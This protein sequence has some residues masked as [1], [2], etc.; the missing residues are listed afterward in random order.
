M[1]KTEIGITAISYPMPCS[2]IGTKVA[3]KVNFL[4]VAWF[5]MV[6][7][8]PPYLMV[9]LGKA[10]Y[11]NEGIKENG[12]FSVNIPSVDMAEAVDYCGLVSGKKID[13]SGVFE[14]FYGKT[15]APMVKECPYNLECK[16]VQTVELPADEMF[17]GE[18]VAAY[19]DSGFLTG[20]V[21]DMS[22]IRPFILN[23]PTT[24]FLGLGSSVGRAWEMGKARIKK[25]E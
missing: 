17:V 4:T 21:P 6:N 11:S 3:G 20:G 13:K 9:A 5:S 2:L 15:G 12:F 7:A 24:T 22:K 23:M 10:H 8:K 18:I 19:A 14:T 16:L 1:E 25:G